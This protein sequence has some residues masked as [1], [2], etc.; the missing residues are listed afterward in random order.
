MTNINIHKKEH[1]WLPKEGVFSSKVLCGYKL[2]FAW[3]SIDTFLFIKGKALHPCKTQHIRCNLR[4]IYSKKSLIFLSSIVTTIALVSI[5][6]QS[7][8]VISKN[9]KSAE[10]HVHALNTFHVKGYQNGLSCWNIPKE[11]RNKIPEF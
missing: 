6:W 8:K 2:F 11:E 9:K 4:N 3:R 10:G 5:S 1:F 7:H